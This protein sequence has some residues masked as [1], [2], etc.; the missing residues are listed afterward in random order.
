MSS[1]ELYTK[2][3]LTNDGGQEKQRQETDGP[4]L[5]VDSTRLTA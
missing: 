3:I 4:D 1:E 2:V 5:F